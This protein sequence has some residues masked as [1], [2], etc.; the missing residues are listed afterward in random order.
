MWDRYMCGQKDPGAFIDRL[1]LKNKRLRSSQKTE[2]IFWEKK[3]YC[4]QKNILSFSFHHSKP[5]SVYSKC[6]T[7]MLKTAALLLV[8]STTLTTATL[9]PGP[10]DNIN[11][12]PE[13]RAKALLGNL[14]QKEKLSLLHGPRYGPCCQWCVSF[15]FVC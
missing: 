2:N 12:T 13:V 6:T 14:T 10:W 7:N 4:K 1:W 8:T 3:Q 11:D 9:V 5:S 15:S